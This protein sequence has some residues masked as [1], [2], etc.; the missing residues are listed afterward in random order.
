MF[1]RAKSKNSTSSRRSKTRRKLRGTQKL[2]SRELL[3]GDITPDNGQLE[4]V[5]TPQADEIQIE[6]SYYYSKLLGSV[7]QPAVK[8]M[9]L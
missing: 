8:A 7:M 3:A 6:N 2:Q 1:K 5:G 4:I 9:I